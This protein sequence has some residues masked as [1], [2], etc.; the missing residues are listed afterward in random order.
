MDK[1]KRAKNLY[2]AL[3]KDSQ[4]VFF[5]SEEIKNSHIKKARLSGYDKD[6]FFL[7]LY[8]RISEKQKFQT[9]PV[10]PS[11]IPFIE[12]K[13]EIDRSTLYSFGGPFEL[14]H[15]DIADIRFF[16][17]SAADPLY[18]LLIVDLFTQKIYTYPIKKRNLLSRKLEIFYEEVRNKRKNKRTRLQTDLEFNQNEIKTLNK[19][20][21]IEMFHTRTRGGKAFAAEQKITEF[22]KLLLKMKIII[23]NEKK[24][25]KS[26]DIIKKVTYN[27][28]NTKIS[29]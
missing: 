1:L 7:A 19:K 6:K 8:S 11:H 5:G 20:Y 24:R 15:A 9:E 23:K 21:N 4:S 3:Q 17:K 29:N 16:A 10:I 13:S 28:N 25:L 18:C 27:M 26:N 14:L 22:K 12:K 2:K